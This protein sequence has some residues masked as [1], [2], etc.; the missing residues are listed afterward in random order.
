MNLDHLVDRLELDSL[1]TAALRFERRQVAE[2]A[3]QLPGTQLRRCQ[4]LYFV[5]VKQVNFADG[6]D[7]LPGTQ[8]RKCQYLY[9]LY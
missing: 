2:G 8:L 7:Q 9:F 4:Y 1:K 6:A 5:L 3:D